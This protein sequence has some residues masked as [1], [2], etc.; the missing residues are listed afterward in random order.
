MNRTVLVTG[1]SSGIGKAVARRLLAESHAVVGISRNVHE[2]AFDNTRFRG[3]RLDLANLETLPERLSQILEQCP[4]I[5]SA[6]FCAGRGRFGNLEEFSLDQIR[7]LIDLN[8]T[9]QA[10][11]A[12]S[13]LPGLKR[14]QC[15]DL[16]FIGS[17]AALKGTR[18]GSIYCASK[19]ALRGFTQALRDECGRGGV[20]ISLINPGMVKSA[21]FDEL[22]FVH[23]EAPQNAIESEDI[24]EVVCSIFKLRPGTVVD[25][26]NLSP[27]TKVI[28]FKS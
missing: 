17:E 4:Q 26:I 7:H 22:D 3:F 27:L 16:I 24:A 18:K 2:S 20:R 8:F 13:L 19:F 25:E 5:D 14:K 1:V 15:G 28:R 6:V 21:F 9:S 23:G 12:R 10:F 11:I